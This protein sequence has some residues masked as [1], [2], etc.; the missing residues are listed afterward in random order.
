M[1]YYKVY[2]NNVQLKHYNSDMF[3]PF[4]GHLQG[5]YINTCTKIVNS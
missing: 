3:Q 5:M 1:L 2:T 4:V